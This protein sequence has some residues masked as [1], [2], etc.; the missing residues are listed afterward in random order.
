MRISDWSSDVCSSD[1][2]EINANRLDSY[3]VLKG[4]V[5]PAERQKSPESTSTPIIRVAGANAFELANRDIGDRAPSIPYLGIYGPD[6]VAMNLPA[7]SRTA[8]RRVRVIP[9][10]YNARSEA[11]R[12]GTEG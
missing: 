4:H 3:G 1:L 8:E 10:S 12:G 6:R 2:A 5:P 7:I 11:R 9:M